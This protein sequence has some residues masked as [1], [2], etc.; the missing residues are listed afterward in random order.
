MAMSFTASLPTSLPPGYILP[1]RSSVMVAEPRVGA[2][3]DVEIPS[4]VEYCSHFFSALG[5]G[6]SLLWPLPTAQK[7][8][9]IKDKSVTDMQRSCQHSCIKLGGEVRIV[10]HVF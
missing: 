9:L 2:G 5:P 10:V 6:L 7:G 8:F 1:S 4:R 3:V